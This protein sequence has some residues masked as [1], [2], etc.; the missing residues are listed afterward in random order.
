MFKTDKKER[1]EEITRL[2]YSYC[3]D[4]FK[5]RTKLIPELVRTIK[6]ADQRV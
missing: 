1:E 4:V 6:V 3:R 5:I 2:C